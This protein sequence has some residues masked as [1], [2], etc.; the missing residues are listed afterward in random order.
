MIYIYIHIYTC[1]YVYTYTRTLQYIYIHTYPEH[2]SF[3]GRASEEEQ[4]SAEFSKMLNATSSVTGS[5]VSRNTLLS[6]ASVVQHQNT[7]ALPSR[8][9]HFSESAMQVRRILVQHGLSIYICI[10]VCIYIYIYM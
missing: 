5:K 6:K 2:E 8:M 1:I 10:Y 4:K 3:F 9:I 7:D